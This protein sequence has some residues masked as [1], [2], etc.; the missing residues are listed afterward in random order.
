[1]TFSGEIFFSSK[2]PESLIVLFNLVVK[3]SELLACSPALAG[4]NIEACTMRWN[5]RKPFFKFSAR[6]LVRV[7]VMQ[8]IK[9]TVHSG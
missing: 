1:M 4:Q 6:L 5:K 2:V 9:A 8:V 7:D 3:H